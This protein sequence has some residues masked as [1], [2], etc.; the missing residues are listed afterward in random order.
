MEW[1]CIIFFEIL[2]SLLKKSIKGTD[3]LSLDCGI[4]QSF[5]VHIAMLS[6][7]KY[8]IENLKLDGV[9]DN[10]S[11]LVALPTKIGGAPGIILRIMGNFLF[12]NS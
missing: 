11:L 4:S 7:D 10:G 1:V 12:K 9:T 5:P 2:Q 8:Q 3:T 6:N